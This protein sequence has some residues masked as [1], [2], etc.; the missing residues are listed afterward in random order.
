MSDEHVELPIKKI[1]IYQCNPGW[2]VVLCHGTAADLH[3]Y[4]GM[5]SEWFA[6]K[7]AAISSGR[8]WFR[9]EPTAEILDMGMTMDFGREMKII[10]TREKSA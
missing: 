9:D 8:E 1:S 10:R 2:E 6:T 7:S 3:V 5:D 4:E